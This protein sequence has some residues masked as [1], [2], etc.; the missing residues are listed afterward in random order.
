MT[1][2][3]YSIYPRYTAGS[4]AAVS[5]DVCRRV[6]AEEV[7]AIEFILQGYQ[8]EEKK[9]EATSKGLEGIA[10][11]QWEERGTIHFKDLFTNKVTTRKANEKEATRV[12]DKRHKGVTDAE[13]LV[14]I[15]KW[16]NRLGQEKRLTGTE[17]V[18]LQHL[19][20][21]VKQTLKNKQ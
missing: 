13:I 17:I 5:E 12:V 2:S 7:D 8:G 14:Q 9:A 20:F 11:Q 16:W 19:L 18:Q 15:D 10:I 1:R 3:S 4:P 21:L 6:L